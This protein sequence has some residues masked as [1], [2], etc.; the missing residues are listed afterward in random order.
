MFATFG[1]VCKFWNHMSGLDLRFWLAWSPASPPMD[2][3]EN[4]DDHEFQTRYD[5]EDCEGVFELELEHEWILDSWDQVAKEWAL[6]K[7]AEMQFRG[8]E[9]TFWHNKDGTD[10]NTLD[11]LE[12]WDHTSEVIE[13]DLKRSKRDH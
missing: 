13:R 11:L 9:A 3:D 8:R 10:I 12:L 2:I 5:V 1:Q 7:D 6:E 4:S